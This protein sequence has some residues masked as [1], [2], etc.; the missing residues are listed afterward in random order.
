METKIDINP[1][2]LRPGTTLKNS[3]YRIISV[4]GQGGFGITY[5]AEQVLINRKVCIKEFFPKDYYRRDVDTQMASPVAESFREM[6]EQFKVKFLKEARAI[7]S[8]THPNIVGIFDLFEENGTAYYAMEYVEG[9]SLYDI[10][11]SKGRLDEATAREYIG[12]VADALGYIHARNLLHL[13]VKPQN[14]MLSAKD[15]RVI[16]IDFG[17]SKHYDKDSGSETTNTLGGHSD[18]YAPIEQYDN[19][20]VREFSPQSDI[21]SMGATLFAMIEGRRPPRARDIDENGFPALRSDI[22]ESMRAAIEKAMQYRRKDRPANVEEFMLILG[23]ARATDS[24]GASTNIDMGGAPVMYGAPPVREGV[25]ANPT[26]PRKDAAA[27]PKKRSKVWIVILLL[28]LVAGAAAAYLFMQPSATEPTATSPIAA[29][30]AVEEIIVDDSVAACDFAE[31]TPSETVATPA[32]APQTDAKVG[33]TTPVVAKETTSRTKN[34]DNAVETNKTASKAAPQTEPTPTAAAEAR[35]ATTPEPQP[36]PA[37]APSAEE[38]EAQRIE[39]MLA[40]GLGR[41]GVYKV[42]DYYNV[43]GKEGVVIEVRNG[44]RNGKIISMREVTQKRWCTQGFNELGRALGASDAKSGLANTELCRKAGIANFPAAS[45]CLDRGE[46]W[47]LPALNELVLIYNVRSKIN[48]TLT[49]H[50][51]NKIS[52]HWHVSSTE[53]DGPQESDRQ[54]PA[55]AVWSVRMLNGQ[56]SANLKTGVD[57]SVRAVTTF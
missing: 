13:D 48:P 28:L 17:L 12:H 26:T 44:G 10:I 18:G 37:K 9:E 33:A 46:G 47:Y 56:K 7:A 40:E 32:P 22:S 21:Y 36:E 25:K 1:A 43:D 14:I 53:Y 27:T 34:L 49:A 24:L 45:W 30:P 23:S 29:E 55:Y 20:G 38:L 54:S 52:S 8:L 11:K 5:L 16:L 51:G 6:M 50:G 35:P 3:S 4:L 41:D 15:K 42:G 31:P 39:Q 57:S 2:E 19:G